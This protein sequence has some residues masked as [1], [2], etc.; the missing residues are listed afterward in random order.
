MRTAPPPAL[1]RVPLSLPG[2][3]HD[4][5]AL[6]SRHPFIRRPGRPA[7]RC[8]RLPVR[9]IR[10]RRLPNVRAASWPC[11]PEGRSNAAIARQLWTTERT[12]ETHVRH[13]FAKLGLM[14]SE[15]G[16]RRLL[17]VLTYLRLR[18]GP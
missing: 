7:A 3:G 11:W 8:W 6:R 14:D 18:S 1:R 9:L 2:G 16:N 5:A 4:R 15:G 10:W 13:I 12:I 17:A